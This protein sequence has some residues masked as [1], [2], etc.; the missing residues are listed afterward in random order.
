[1]TKLT[2]S[3]LSWRTFIAWWWS[4]FSRDTPLALTT[5]SLMRSFFSAGPA[6]N[7]SEIAIDGSPSSKWGLSL[8]SN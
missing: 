5:L 3:P 2:V 6:F 7:T 8:G 1:M 4:T